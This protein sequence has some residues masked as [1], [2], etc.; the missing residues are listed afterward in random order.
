LGLTGLLGIA[1]P[2]YIDNWGHAG[3]AL[4]GF[5]LGL[6]H[7]W[8]L[9]NHDRPPAWG[10][11][12]VTSLAIAG[13]GL[14]QFAADRREAPARRELA[15]RLDLMAHESA[16][17]VLRTAA[18]L[19]ESKINARVFLR[20]IQNVADILDRGTTRDDYRRIWNLGVDAQTRALSDEE[21]TELEL[22]LGHLVSQ[23]LASVQFFLDRG[24]TRTEY[25]RLKTLADL[26]QT[27]VLSDQEKAE[28]KQQ[29]GALGGEVR[30]GLEVRVREFWKHRRSQP[31][32]WTGIVQPGGLDSHS[33]TPGS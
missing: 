5:P 18:V 22:K 6:F 8:F 15:A 26:A 11:G 14:A 13:C 20:S 9:R 29:I 3:G 10:M 4:V 30:R 23:L 12:V 33:P 28:F 2:R 16:Y 21:K 19:G 31:A 27:R 17:R 7:R 25:G 32:A 1:F 24:P